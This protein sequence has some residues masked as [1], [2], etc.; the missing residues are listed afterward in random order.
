MSNRVLDLCT[1]CS[2]GVPCR[3]SPNPKIIEV[4]WHPSAL[5]YHGCVLG[6]FCSNLD[7][8][9]AVHAE[10]LAVIKAIKLAWLHA[11]HKVWIETDSLLV[12]QFFRYPHLV[13]WRLRV[14]WLNC[15]HRLQ[16][17]LFKISHIFREGNHGAAALADHGALDSG[18]TCWDTAPS[19]ILSFYHRD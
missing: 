18:C 11:W 7:V 14:D 12:T 10:V 1:I 17:M 4:T 9:S 3:P 13:P 16:H 2:F 8:S 6:A 15:L 19:F 5:D